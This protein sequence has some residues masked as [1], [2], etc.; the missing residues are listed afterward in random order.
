MAKVP[1]TDLVNTYDVTAI[2]ANFAKIEAAF[3]DEV[4]FRDNPIGANTIE[5]DIDLNGKK[6]Y[7]LPAPTLNSQAARLQDVQNAIAGGDANL[8]TFTQA[9][10]GAVVRTLQAK[11]RD[12]V[13]VKDFGAVGD[14]VANDTV[15]LQ[16]ASTAA[17]ALGKSLHIP[18]GTY[19]YSSWTGLV[20]S[21]ITIFGDGSSNTILKYTGIGDALVLGTPATFSQ[22]V[23]ISGFTVE[24]NSNVNRI[25][26]ATA[27]ARCQWTDINVREAK[28]ASGIGFVFQGCMLNR[29]DSLVCSTDRQ[30]MINPPYE[31][32]N[33][34]SLSP[35]GNSANNT[36]TNLYAEGSGRVASTIEVGLRISG[37]TQNVFIGGSPE[38]CG[39][40]GVLIAASSGNNTFIG[41]GMENLDATGGDCA[42][43]GVSTRYINCY[44]SHKFILQGR[45][46]AVE[47]GYYER[48][49]IDSLSYRNSV[50]DVVVNQWATGAGG[51]FDSGIGTQTK[52][53]Y[54]ADL[55]AF[56]SEVYPRF[57]AYAPSVAAN[58]TGA[59]AQ[60]T[61]GFIEVFDDNNNFAGN[62]FTAPITGR[63]QLNASVSLDAL[64]TAAT[65]TTIRIITSNR[66]YVQQKGVNPKAGGL[67][68]AIS[69]AVVADMDA[70]DT[71]T[72]T[73]QVEGMAGNTVS[74]IGNGTT[75]W[76][77]FSG[78]LG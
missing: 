19:L 2:N 68:D 3:E 50:S 38:S 25:I 21:G 1:L 10:T 60:A 8:I 47:G 24:G 29:F 63:Y 45:S 75:M 56:I 43:A 40:W 62:T 70:G 66:T 35:H 36:F 11:N 33:I 15:S 49:Q 51:L 65:L 28:S 22:G 73:I 39:T 42:D 57:L 54:D 53:I 20:G 34:E 26:V 16:A 69:I 61:I 58:Q 6:L 7:N 27:L 31:A 76:T 5:S 12:T 37:G 72:V 48:I 44:S 46:C 77:T 18:S 52:N 13:S 59:G 4:L 55:S 67:Q 9:G 74:V 14:G 23:N 17:L 78:S 30:A 41:V 64:S 71:A 32:F